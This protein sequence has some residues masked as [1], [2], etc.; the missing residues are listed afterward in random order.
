MIRT[1]MRLP[2]GQWKR[3]RQEQRETIRANTEHQT[4]WADKQAKAEERRTYAE[5]QLPR[6][7]QALAQAEQRLTDRQRTNAVI[8]AAWD[9]LTPGQ[10]EIIQREDAALQQ[11]ALARERTDHQQR[12]QERERR[13]TYEPY[14]PPAPQPEM[15]RTRGLGLS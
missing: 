4:H 13:P 12:K 7:A 9:R 14:Q 10:R 8:D 2:F 3:I 6:H 15:R 11:Q 5:G 1:T